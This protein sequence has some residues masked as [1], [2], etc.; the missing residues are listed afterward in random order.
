MGMGTRTALL[1]LVGALVCTSAS[2]AEMIDNPAYEAWAQY[3]PGSFVSHKGVTQTQG[4]NIVAS[5][6]N[7]LKEVTAEKVV[8][9]I[10][11]SVSMGGQQMPPSTQNMDIPAKVEEPDE[12]AKPK[13]IEKGTEELEVK[14]KKIKTEWVKVEMTQQ[15]VTMTATT[16]SSDEVPGKL[17]KM[18]SET[19][20]PMVSK[21]E[22][23]VED[24]KIEK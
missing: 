16:W 1:L 23:T 18:V 7:T 20:T 13:E 11:T 12:T 5:T 6:T 24:Y 9:E 17:V 3:E 10:K 14:G 8:I 19:T 15:G 2:A 21:T 4:M 22:M